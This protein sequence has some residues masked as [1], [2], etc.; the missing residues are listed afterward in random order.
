M[1]KISTFIVGLLFFILQ[2]LDKI[3]LLEFLFCVSKD[4]DII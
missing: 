1:N 2:I 3:D 4:R